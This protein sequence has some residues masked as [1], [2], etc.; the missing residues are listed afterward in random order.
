MITLIP[1]MTEKAY[2]QS[3]Q[4]TYVFSVPM[5]ANKAGIT[6]AVETQYEGVKVKDVRVVVQNGKK[7]RAYRGKRNAPGTA[8]RKDTKKAYVS[9]AEGSIQLFDETPEEETK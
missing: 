6:S 4:N 9:L 1:R 3:T 5:T 8:H 7:V 2:A